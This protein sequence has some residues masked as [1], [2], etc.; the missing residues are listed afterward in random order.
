MRIFLSVYHVKNAISGCEAYES[1]IS[2]IIRK[3]DIDILDKYSV[4]LTV[5]LKPTS[6]T[7]VRLSASYIWNKNEKAFRPLR[8]IAGCKIIFH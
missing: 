1:E 3:P 7:I 6:F 5:Q 8:G 2:F 4:Q